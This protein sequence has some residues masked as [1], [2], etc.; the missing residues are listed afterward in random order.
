MEKEINQG[1]CIIVYTRQPEKSYPEGLAY[2]AHFALGSNGS[3]EALNGNYGILYPESTIDSEDIIHVKGLKSPWIFPMAESGYGIAAV[4][5]NEDGS[6]DEES[7][8]KALIFT[9]ADFIRFEERGLLSLN[10]DT[11]VKSIQ[12]HYDNEEKCYRIM[13][14][15]YL[16]NTHL[17]I[18]EDILS[19]LSRSEGCSA[20]LEN[21]AEALCMPEGAVPGNSVEISSV[22]SSQISI[23]WNKPACTKIEVQNPVEISC[24][25]ELESLKATAVYS[26]GS[27]TEK[28]VVWDIE[29]LDFDKPGAYHVSGQV[30]DES[31]K[32]PLARG[33]GDPIIFKWEGKYYFIATND[34]EN[35][36]GLYVREADSIPGLFH[37]GIEQHLILPLDEERGFIQTF[38]APEF[39]VIGGE[40]YILFAV[41]GTKWGPQCHLM[42]LKKGGHIIDPAAWEDPVRVQRQDGSWLT[43]DGITLDMTYIEVPG[44]SYMVWSYRMH[45]G[46]PKDT[47]SMLYIATV[48]PDSPWKLTSEPVLLSR[49]LY[50]WENLQNTINNEG[51]YAFIANGKIYLAYSGGASDSFTYTLGM[52]TANV[53]DNLLDLS[54][55]RKREAPV[56]S[57]YSVKGEFGP[58]H[59]SFFEDESGNLMIAYHGE[60][61]I[62]SHIRCVGIR[63]VH[64]NILN[65][66]V[67]D[68]SAEEDLN[69]ALVNV[70]TEIRI[71]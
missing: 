12:C 71:L 70:E 34:N 56:L 45:I 65:E 37:E 53:G 47:G 25:E 38:W 63:R 28:P 1:S 42:K 40:L 31:F 29:G 3:Y 26:D 66:P 50:G 18:S 21:T 32:F 15:D 20:V 48:N 49:P 27:T 67:F 62:D 46:T 13:W 64:F 5:I 10:T 55:W 2:S 59:N 19:L 60:E 36:V 35:D 43:K 44:C 54:V 14:E 57:H 11:D 6:A 23:H 9:T 30:K 24:K 39:H 33:Y 52:L 16:G 41:S 7:R 51:P 8:G 68:M 58:G 69:P 61:S 17:N 22:L 4:R